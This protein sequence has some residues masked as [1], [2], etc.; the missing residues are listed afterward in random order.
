MSNYIG[1]KEIISMYYGNNDITSFSMGN[2]EIWTP[3]GG[4]GGDYT[5]T[6]AQYFT[7]NDSSITGYIGNDTTIVLPRSYSEVT[8]TQEITGSKCYINNPENWGNKLSQR[9]N[10]YNYMTFSDGINTLRINNGGASGSMY[11][12]IYDAVTGVTTNPDTEL[13]YF[14]DWSQV[15]LIEFSYNN[16]INSPYSIF[17]TTSSYNMFQYPLAFYTNRLYTYDSFNSANFRNQVFTQANTNQV[18]Y[19]PGATATITSFIDG[20]TYSVTS[21][22]D[23]AFTGN[24]TIT[25]VTIL[26]NIKTIGLGAFR[27]CSNLSKLTLVDD[28]TVSRSI[29]QQAFGGC[30]NLSEFHYTGS[31]ERWVGNYLAGYDSNPLCASPTQYSKEIYFNGSSSPTRELVIPSG[32]E[33]GNYSFYGC[34]NITSITLSEGVLS[35]GTQAFAYCTGLNDTNITLPSTIQ[36]IGDRVFYRCTN[37]NE[38]TCL[39][40]SVPTIDRNAFSQIRNSNMNSLSI[41]VPSSSY[42]DYVY[43]TWSDLVT[44]YGYNLYAIDGIPEISHGFSLGDWYINL[45]PNG[46]GNSYFPLDGVNPTY[47]EWQY[48]K[49]D[50][51]IHIL[52]INMYLQLDS[53]YYKALY[54]ADGN[55]LIF[56]HADTSNPTSQ[57]GFYADINNP[58][59][60]LIV[61]VDSSINVS[62]SGSITDLGTVSWTLNDCIVIPDATYYILQ[63]PDGINLVKFNPMTQQ[64]IIK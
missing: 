31:V 48:E 18:I 32:A 38:I 20:N 17:N 28:G 43:S 54:T 8:G 58:S 9:L 40:T 27:T 25:D 62:Y 35:I 64:P 23:S 47:A 19:C 34:N 36:Y 21:I 44:D 56:K 49:N 24:N 14:S 1:T 50:L 33:V 30:Y 26:E 63:D 15:Y 13:P 59:Y 12:Q 22:A 7:F 55:G 52:D 42:W 39:A 53:D 5:P 29:L 6:S 46:T 57:A 11:N 16:S 60:I 37:I 4:G 3:G 2:S 61:N 51:T 10:Y 45:N 41:Y